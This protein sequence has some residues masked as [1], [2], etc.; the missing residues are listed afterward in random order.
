MG[1]PGSF[2]PK[3]FQSEKVLPRAIIEGVRSHPPATPYK[4]RLSPETEGRSIKLRQ[5]ANRFFNAAI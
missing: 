1:L 3:L 5:L 2:D 4:A